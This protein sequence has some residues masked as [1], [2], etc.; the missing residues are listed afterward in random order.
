MYLVVWSTEIPNVNVQDEVRDEY[1][2]HETYL[3]ARKQYDELLEKDDLYSA[4]ITAPLTSTDYSFGMEEHL[5]Y[6]A[7]I[8]REYRGEEWDRAEEQ[9]EAMDIEPDENGNR[10]PVADDLAWDTVCNLLEEAGEQVSSLKEEIN[11]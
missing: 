3:S 6:L 8:A 2:A 4:S 7:D 1:E 11:E 5:S 9:A 10:V